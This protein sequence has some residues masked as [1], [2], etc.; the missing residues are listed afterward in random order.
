M[1]GS[2]RQFTK[3][4]S[5]TAKAYA[6]GMLWAGLFGAFGCIAKAIFDEQSNGDASY[7]DLVAVVLGILG[8]PV[9]FL[10]ARTIHPLLY[11]LNSGILRCIGSIVLIL[12]LTVGPFLAFGR[13]WPSIGFF[14]PI[15]ISVFLWT[16]AFFVLA[17]RRPDKALVTME[18][19]RGGFQ[20][21]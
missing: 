7:A 18:E 16:I 4:W 12:G 3:P 13:F 21:L 1:N 19:K 14:L 5:D 17:E 11:S 6:G 2:S 10:L 8:V 15:I 20:K 9:L